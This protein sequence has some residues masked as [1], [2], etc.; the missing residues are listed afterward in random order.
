MSRGVKID[1]MS[2]GA[3]DFTT[4]NSGNSSKTADKRNLYLK[5]AMKSKETNPIF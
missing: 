1:L 4:I 3:A 5:H 2:A